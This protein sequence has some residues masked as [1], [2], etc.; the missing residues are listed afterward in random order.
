MLWRA[1]AA[2]RIADLGPDNISWRIWYSSPLMA[3]LVFIDSHKI[4]SPILESQE[5]LN[6]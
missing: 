5:I 1:R 4:Q 2:S 6:D 3:I